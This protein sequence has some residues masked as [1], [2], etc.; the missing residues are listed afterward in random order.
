[1]KAQWKRVSM[2][3]S[4][5]I[6][7]CDGKFVAKIEWREDWHCFYGEVLGQDLGNF[8]TVSSAKSEIRRFIVRVKAIK[9]WD[10]K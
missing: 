2:T 4:K 6:L 7:E 8:K 5:H 3:P 1:M 10:Q 9:L